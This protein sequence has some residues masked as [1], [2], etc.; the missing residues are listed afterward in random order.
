M[1]QLQLLI[2]PWFCGCSSSRR[3][4]AILVFP[5]LN[6]PWLPSP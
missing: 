6:L 4:A 2:Y 3:A 1:D 5:N